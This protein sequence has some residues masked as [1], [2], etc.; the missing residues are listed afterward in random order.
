MNVS[1]VDGFTSVRGPSFANA[2][3]VG[4]RFDN[5]TDSKAGKV[6]PPANGNP[7]IVPPWLQGDGKG[8]GNGGIVPPWLETPFHILPW[9]FPIVPTDP[10][11]GAEMV[12]VAPTDPD[13][14]HIM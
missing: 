2:N 5:S 10:V 9:P 12:G 6:K 7:G 1:R 3:K 8:N 13:T 14:P 11:I 4:G